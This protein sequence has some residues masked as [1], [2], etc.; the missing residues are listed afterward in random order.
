MILYFYQFLLLYYTCTTL[1]S[2]LKHRMLYQDYTKRGQ[3]PKMGTFSMQ[4]GNVGG[5]H[6]NVNGGNHEALYVYLSPTLLF[7]NIYH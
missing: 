1:R 4:M 3:R 6:T 7:G 2:V 5:S